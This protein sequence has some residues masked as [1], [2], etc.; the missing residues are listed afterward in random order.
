[1]ACRAI[2]SGSHHPGAKSRRPGWKGKSK[3]PSGLR[4]EHRACLGRFRPAGDNLTLTGFQWASNLP[5]IDRTGCLHH[6]NPVGTRVI[7]V[8]GIDHM[9]R[10]RTQKVPSRTGTCRTKRYYTTKSG[11][12]Y[13][14][15]FSSFWNRPCSCWRDQGRRKAKGRT[16]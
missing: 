1:M 13:P 5:R 6:G 14:P 8:P 7:Q 3:P 16:A 11:K 10:S 12:A 4:G 2:L 15:N 9:G